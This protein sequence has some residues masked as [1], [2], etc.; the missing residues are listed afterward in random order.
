MF[1]T[2]R[3]NT[4]TCA[5]ELLRVWD[6]EKWYNSILK[7]STSSYKL[8]QNIVLDSCEWK[9]WRI[10][11]CV[12]SLSYT[13]THVTNLSQIYVCYSMYVFLTFFIYRPLSVCML[14][15]ACTQRIYISQHA[16]AIYRQTVGVHKNWKYIY[17]VTY[18]VY[19]KL[20]YK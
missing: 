20:E 14:P 10:R 13:G 9:L 6:R 11:F 7:V 1:F 8:I 15:N 18:K 5:C 17:T 12:L 2:R 4:H 16:Y 3:K 19:N